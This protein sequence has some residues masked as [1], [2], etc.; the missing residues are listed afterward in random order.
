MWAAVFILVSGALS[1]ANLAIEA[2]TQVQHVPDE[3]CQKMSL[4][5]YNL[6][7]I[8]DRRVNLLI[9][10]R[11]A[12]ALSESKEAGV[13]LALNSTLRTCA[14]QGALRSNN[15]PSAELA[16]EFCHPETEKPGESLHNYGLAVDFK[17]EGYVLFGSS[18]CYTW[19]KAEAGG[20]GLI[21]R[22]GEPWHWSMTGK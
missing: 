15:C 13:P 20:Y 11:V 1:Q 6:P 9:Y 22:P 16:A 18:P 17:C 2:S 12:R 7:V 5:E 8:K 19:L 4:R 10:F 21:N 14:E 3:S